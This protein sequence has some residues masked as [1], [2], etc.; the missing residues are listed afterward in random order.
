MTF[1]GLVSFDLAWCDLNSWAFDSNVFPRNWFEST[2]NSSSISESWIDS[3]HDSSGFPGNWLRISSR[4]MQIPRYWFRS[5]HD[6]NSFQRINSESTHDSSG[7]PGIDSNRLM[8]QAKNIWFWDYS[9]FNSESCP[10][11]QQG[12]LGMRASVLAGRAGGDSNPGPVTW[13]QFSIKSGCTGIILHTR[14]AKC[15]YDAK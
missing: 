9:W 12:E 4:L 15:E 3:T 14:K 5:T 8:T 6:S 2:R 7:S 10:C 11:L 13:T 1:F